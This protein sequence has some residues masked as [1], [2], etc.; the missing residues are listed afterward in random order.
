MAIFKTLL[1][2]VQVLSALGVIGLVLLQHGKGADVGAAFGSGASGSLFGATGSANFLSRTTAVLASLFFVCT[3]GLTLLGN[4]KPQTSLGVMGASQAP[5]AS[6]PAASASAPAAAA[7][8][9]SSVPA[10]PAV[11]K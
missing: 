4:Y 1:V 6:A 7:S 9:A 8:G 5:V 11:P 10:A 2:L 3:L